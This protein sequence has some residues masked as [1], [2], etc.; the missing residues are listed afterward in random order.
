V[1]RPPVDFP[2]YLITDRKAIRGRDL[3]FVVE[4]ALKGGAKAVQLRE[5]D[6]S[7]RDL[8]GAA[9]NLRSL[10][11]RYGALLF[12]NDRVDVAQTVD[13]DG[14]HLGEGSI[15][16][17]KA[18]LILGEEKLIGVSCHD[19]IS[20]LTAQE[21][22]A[23][24]ITFGPVFYTPSKAA[25]GDPAGIEKLAEITALLR[26]PVFAIGGI[27]MSNASRVMAAGAHGA[28][29]ISAVMAAENPR[30]ETQSLLSAL[31]AQED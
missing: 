27:N 16:A 7:G 11:A 10:T 18:R 19:T 22:D 1:T 4:E 17:D 5:K 3:N 13:A 29:L 8:C 20:A 21:L 12:I 6:L 26:I 9:C 31:Q 2:L 23:D 15:P 28:A 30:E 25:Y 24:F 14:V